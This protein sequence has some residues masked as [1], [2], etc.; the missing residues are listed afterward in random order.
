MK[1]PIN[2]IKRMQQLAGLVNE[3]QDQEMNLFDIIELNAEELATKFNLDKDS[4]MVSGVE[5]DEDG[6]IVMTDDDGNQ[7]DF[8]DKRD[9]ENKKQ[10]YTNKQK[11][12]S[13]TIG[14]F[15]IVYIQT[16]Q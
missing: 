4:V 12:G 2:E 9:W 13:I 6:S 8:I 15:K 14:D 5:D 7:V 16:P 10:F 3:N 11:K 1:Q